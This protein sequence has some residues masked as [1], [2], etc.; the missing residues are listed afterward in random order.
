MTKN[1]IYELK[2]RKLIKQISNKK[3]LIKNIKKKKL[4][5]YCGFDPTYKSLH[6]GHLLL[7]ITLKRFIKYNFNIF[8]LI[9]STTAIIGDPSFTKNKRKK[10]SKNKIKIFK[11]QIITQIKN[12]VNKKNKIII[13]N[14]KKWL[15]NIKLIYFLKKIGKHFILNQ[16]LNKKF[17]KEKI[18]NKK[19]G[20][21]YSEITYNLL[22][23]YDYL[24]LYKKFNI[25]L[26]IGGSD[27]WGN[28][29]S[30]I[31]LINKKY[32][33]EVL[34]LTIPL[35][36]K[37]NGKKFSKSTNNNIWLNSFLTTPY[38]FYQYWLNTKDTHLL[39]LYKQFTN[40]SLKKIK[41]IFKKYNIKKLK[42]KLSKYITKLVH[43]KKETNKSI[44]ATKIFF[45]KKIKNIKKKHLEILNKINLPKITIKFNNNINIKNLL[46]LLKIS[47]Y[48]SYIHNLILN[49]SIYVNK[50]IIINTNY[51]FN[52]KDKLYNKYTILSKGKKKFF[53]IKW[54]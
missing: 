21:T 18:K 7:L 10:L 45:N 50:K 51:T 13:L 52:I 5:I 20:I 8:I 14:N 27:Q 39:L 25:N 36:T 54:I 3:L 46:I 37:K 44:F 47:K 42:T 12:I 9:G 53:L 35:M 11:K 17:I 28:I 49:K 6:I 33:K 38:E 1:I 32:K 19:H 26:Q 4:N 30:G 22:Q 41:N 34:G 2:K 31:N 16:I 43:G 23:S 29:T 15:N 40:F 48:K 24:F